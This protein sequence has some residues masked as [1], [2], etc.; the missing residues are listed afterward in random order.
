MGDYG[1]FGKG[2]TGYVHYMQA[3]NESGSSRGSRR[4]KSGCGSVLLIVAI[5]I[6][7]LAM[8]CNSQVQIC[9]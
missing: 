5:I 3:Q 7:G 8:S 1:Y 6:L 9:V 2:L 4:G